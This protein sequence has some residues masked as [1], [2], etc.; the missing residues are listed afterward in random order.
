MGQRRRLELRI[1]RFTIEPLTNLRY[2]A[3]ILNLEAWAGIEPAL[4]SHRFC[5]P[6]QSHSDTTPFNCA[7]GRPLEFAS[8][9]NGITIRPRTTLRSASP[10]HSSSYTS[11][12]STVAQSPVTFARYLSYLFRDNFS[13]P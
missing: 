11:S 8:N 5:R 4:L 3:I 6:T 10:Q 9:N 1:T 13:A 12:G 2:V 7:Q